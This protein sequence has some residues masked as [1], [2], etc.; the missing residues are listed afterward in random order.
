MNRIFIASLA[1]LAALTVFTGCEQKPKAEQ[2][3]A[4]VPVVASTGINNATLIWEKVKNAA[5]YQVVLN[6]DAPLSTEGS[7]ITIQGL[8]P[9]TTYSLKMKA[10]APRE[11]RSYPSS[12][13][14]WLRIIR[15]R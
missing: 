1:A 7:T 12:L 15:Y 5:S 13:A 11:S 10:I 14:V 6:D 2:L 8:S 3:P 4:P 9:S